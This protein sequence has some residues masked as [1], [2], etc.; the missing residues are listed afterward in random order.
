ME[1][2]D[3]LKHDSEYEDYLRVRIAELNMAARQSDRSPVKDWIWESVK[4]QSI[5]GAKDVY[6]KRE[7]QPQSADESK[8]Y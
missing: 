3:N 1:K 2:L 8:I 7:S 6:C 5:H 4:N